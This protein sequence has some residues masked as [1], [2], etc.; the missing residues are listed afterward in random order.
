MINRIA[1]ENFKC[2]AEKTSLDFSRFTI[3]YGKNGRGKSSVIQS[4]LL[5]GQNVKK[6]D[7]LTNISLKGAFVDLGNFSDVK[8]RYS[9]SDRIQFDIAIDDEEL[10][11]TY[12]NSTNGHTMLHLDDLKRNGIPL[13][14]NVGTD[15]QPV[16]DNIKNSYA[17]S[18]LKSLEFFRLMR[19]VSANRRGPANYE[20]R[21]DDFLREDIGSFGERLI[22]GISKQTTDFKQRFTEALSFILSGAYMSIHDDTHSDRIE[23]LLDSEDDSE[24]FKPSN[25]GYGYSYIL[26]IIYQILSAENGSTI[27]IENPEAHLYPGVQ[28]KLMQWIISVSTQKQL[29]IIL[30]THSDHVING[31]RISVKNDNVPRRDVSILYLDRKDIRK[32][33]CVV[34]IKVDNNGTLSE[35]PDDFMD[36]WTKQMLALL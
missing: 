31:L 14:S 17:I 6:R 10:N 29:Q 5:L 36:E 9:T 8:N 22:N 1:I 7:A 18:E 11:L 2:F 28:S 26:P 27:L 25:V 19:Y 16:D 24:G 13:I 3:L 20:E 32:S 35:N 4:L 21:Q 15:N 34:P 23:M 12:G 33:P 30:E